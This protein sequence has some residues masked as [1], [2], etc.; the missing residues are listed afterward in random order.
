[1]QTL[2]VEAF[3]PL[4]VAF[5]VFVAVV[6]ARRLVYQ[7]RN[8]LSPEQRQAA[9]DAFRSRLVHPNASEVEQGIGAYL[10]ER[11]LSLYGDHQTVLTEQI[12]IRRPTPNP[13]NPVEPQNPAE[14]IEAFLPLDLESQK[15]VLDLTAQGWGKGFCFATDGEGNFYWI[16]AND[17][18]LPDARVYFAHTD[19]V[20]NEQVATSLDELLSWPRIIHSPEAE[21]TP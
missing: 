4:V 8:R 15:Y 21:G 18:R 16:P 2:L 17:T 10:P 14:W 11:L 19:P 1:M 20:A 12:E 9:R 5:V 3:G 7:Y 13:E 6:G